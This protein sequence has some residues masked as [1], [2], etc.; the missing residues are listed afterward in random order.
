MY[1]R[2]IPTFQHV[3]QAHNGATSPNLKLCDGQDSLHGVEVAPL[4]CCK[5]SNS[6][7]LDNED[8]L[9]GMT[10]VL[11]PHASKI[12]HFACCEGSIHRNVYTH[13]PTH[14]HTHKLP[15]CIYAFKFMYVYVEIHTNI[16]ACMYACMHA[17]M[18]VCMSKRTYAQTRERE[19]ELALSMYRL[20]F[21]YKACRTRVGQW[22]GE[23]RMFPMP[24][25]ARERERD[26][27]T[28][29]RD[30]RGTSTCIRENMGGLSG[31]TSEGWWTADRHHGLRNNDQF[32]RED[33][34]GGPVRRGDWGVISPTNLL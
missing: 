12:L 1:C 33:P 27:E 3:K 26:R 20:T 10:S 28:R 6:G 19:R 9:V 4:G 21:S 34:A 7:R 2:V 16:C 29:S 14:T 15:T 31:P 5:A 18:Y 24:G 32:A 13:T 17:C 25:R 11:E 22:L 8:G 23:L 30:V